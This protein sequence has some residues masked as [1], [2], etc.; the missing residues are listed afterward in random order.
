[1]FPLLKMF[2]RSAIAAIFL[3]KMFL[4][5][6]SDAGFFNACTRSFNAMVE[7][8]D[9]GLNGI[10]HPWG[11]NSTVSDIHNLLVFLGLFSSI[12]NDLLPCLHTNHL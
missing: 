4:N 11:G 5:G 1:M 9:A 3:S 7:F 8:S 12:Y 2:W 6:D 10:T